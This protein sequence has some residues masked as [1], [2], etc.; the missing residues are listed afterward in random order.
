MY[1]KIIIGPDLFYY[2]L[3]Y[4][5]S[6]LSVFSIFVFNEV[7]NFFLEFLLK[8]YLG[9]YKILY[10]NKKN[11]FFFFKIFKILKKK[12]SLLWEVIY[13]NLN[14]IKLVKKRSYIKPFKLELVFS[15]HY[16]FFNF[17]SKNFYVYSFNRLFFE[18][19]NLTFFEN[20]MLYNENLDYKNFLF[21]NYKYLIFELIRKHKYK[22]YLEYYVFFFFKQFGEILNNVYFKI[23]NFQDTPFYYN[24]IIILL[25]ITKNKLFYFI[26][27]TNCNLYKLFYE[28]FFY[29]IYK[30]YLLYFF[31]I[32]IYNFK[33]ILVRLNILI[34]FFNLFINLFLK[35]V[36]TLMNNFLLKSF[37]LVNWFKFFF[38]IINSLFLFNYL[39][40]INVFTIILITKIN[41]L[42]KIALKNI[43]FFY[44]LL[45][46]IIY[47]I[48]FCLI[49]FIVIVIDLKDIKYKKKIFIINYFENIINYLW[50]LFISQGTF[51]LKKLYSV[52]FNCLYFLYHLVQFLFIF[53]LEQKK[54]KMFVRKFLKGYYNWLIKKYCNS[55]LFFFPDKKKI[56]KKLNFL[57]N[58][59]W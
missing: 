44:K 25:N 56:N 58:L 30:F 46:I 23:L 15:I 26:K 5:Y 10:S 29:Q 59:K 49:K 53:C 22:K 42:L 41:L 28:L 2:W 19:Y 24:F 54:N 35:L 7:Y 1:V 17:F 14:D 39:I 27:S 9:V 21:K 57:F 4:W 11:L 32:I 36:I 8:F 3:I 43:Y 34:Y 55:Y 13:I 12:V 45:S 50:I 6:I 31:F 38:N 51:F 40:M 52:I 48:Y 16:N 47:K 37:F 20:L 18:F 33:N